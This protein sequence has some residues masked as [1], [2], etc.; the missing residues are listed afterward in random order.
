MC[1]EKTTCI[2]LQVREKEG[3]TSEGF[4]A[5]HVNE[6]SRHFSILYKLT[7]IVVRLM[8]TSHIGGCNTF[9]GGGNFWNFA[10]VSLC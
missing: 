3:C 6:F 5:T 8:S 2:G 9:I 4:H 7:S 1:E 10:E